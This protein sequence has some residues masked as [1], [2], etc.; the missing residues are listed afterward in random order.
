M[1]L[2][3][4]VGLPL[5]ERV[6]V[7]LPQDVSVP[8]PEAVTELVEECE[9]D[10]VKECAESDCEALVDGIPVEERVFELHGVLLP[11]TEGDALTVP[12]GE[13]EREV[14]VL[15]VG[16]GEREELAETVAQVVAQCEELCEPE[17]VAL[18][19]EVTYPVAVMLRLGDCEAHWL[20]LGVGE[21][22]R[23]RVGEVE[24]DPV[25]EWLL[26]V[27][28]ER[29]SVAHTVEVCVLHIVPLNEGIA[30]EVIEAVVDELSEG[31]TETLLEEEPPATELEG[32]VVPGGPSAAAPPLTLGL[33]VPHPLE[34]K[35]GVWQGDADTETVALALEERE[36]L[37]VEHCESVRVPSRLP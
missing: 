2:T 26:L 9:K 21:L 32:V 11:L 17:K 10:A 35:E 8:L 22:L 15:A 31:D 18:P 13:R 23:H 7:V 33:P 16:E 3:V 20:L 37:A 5:M 4:V 1:A 27:E 6:P 24:G 36:P 25:P 34:E 19:D 14:H 12:L 28:R 30:L 29:L